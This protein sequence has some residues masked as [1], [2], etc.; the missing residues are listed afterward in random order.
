MPRTEAVVDLAA[1]AANVATLKSTTAAELMA[2]VKADGYGHGMLPSARAA[3][4]GG[5]SWLGVAMLEE[6]LALR[7]A[8]VDERNL[9]WLW[10][11]HETEALR[12]ALAADVD[13]SVASVAGL[14]LVVATAAELGS[15]AR[16]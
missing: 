11:P 10:A 4:A 3:V 16:V 14:E 2:V 7:A 13:I 5:A 8:G 6:A 9:A 1:I 15:T 12:A